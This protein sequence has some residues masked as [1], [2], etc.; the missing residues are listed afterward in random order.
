MPTLECISFNTSGW[1]PEHSEEGLIVWTNEVRDRME[2]RIAKKPPMLP[3][4]YPME[5]IQKFAGKRWQNDTTAIIAVDVLTVRGMSIVRSVL[6][7]KIVDGG[8]SDPMVSY[9]GRIHI[10]FRDF[11]YE[12]K[13]KTAPE[14]APTQRE[15]LLRAEHESNED[16]SFPWEQDPYLP[17]RTG[18]LCCESDNSVYDERFPD[19]PL[20]RLRQEMVKIVASIITVREVRNAVPFQGNVPV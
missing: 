1:T 18:Y 5:G 14:I 15:T 3:P 20:T 8:T 17:E 16:A 13:I 7:R 12:I 6:K 11:A 4:L 10:P 9:H 2:Y 19:D